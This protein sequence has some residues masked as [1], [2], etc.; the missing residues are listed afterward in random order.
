M[1]E[2]EALCRRL[3]IMVNGQLQCI[4]TP[5]HLKS[6]FGQGY[7]LDVT[8]AERSEDIQGD[9]RVAQINN[10]LQI[11]GQYF[12]IRLVEQKLN[13][14]TFQVTFV[15]Q[16]IPVSYMFGVLEQV[17]AQLHLSSYALNQTTL[18]QIFIQ[19]A[20]SLRLYFPF[21]IQKA[22]QI[23][24]FVL[25]M[26]VNDQIFSNHNGLWEISCV[27]VVAEKLLDLNW[28]NLIK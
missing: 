22:I 8:F 4:G 2:C 9:Q 24:K 25:N 19:M 11:L 6:R 20:G 1:E 14:A 5:Q 21:N 3:G 23:K 7:Q 13:K 27:V 17:K 28:D 15:N 12:A 16:A 10:C 26:T 18:E